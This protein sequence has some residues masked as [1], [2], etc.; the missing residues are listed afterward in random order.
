MN[1]LPFAERGQ[2]K[3]LHR[4]TLSVLVNCSVMCS[5]GFAVKVRDRDDYAVV[6]V[7]RILVT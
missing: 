2:A 4:L 7:L 3:K 1:Y 5:A 6:G